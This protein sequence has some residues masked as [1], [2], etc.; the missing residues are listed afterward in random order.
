VTG[1]DNAFFGPGAGVGN[2]SGANNTFVGVSAGQSNTTESLNTF[3]GAH[4]LGAG[5]ITNATAIG[6]SA[7]VTRSN[8]LVLGSINNVNFAIADTKVGIG[9]TAPVDL[10]HV[11]GH[12]TAI[13]VTDGSIST[14]LF[15]ASS[16]GNGYVGTASASPFVLRTGDIDRVIIDASG[17]VGIGTGPDHTLSVNGN[18]DKPGGG[19]WDNLSDERLKTIRGRFT[20]GLKALRQ[21]QPLRYE[22]KR[23]NALGIKSDGEHIGFGAQS[24]Q[25]A[26]PEAVTRNDKGYLL[27][28]NDPIIWTMLNAIKEQ[29]K[30]I[31][32]LK[33][34]VGQLQ[35]AAHRQRVRRR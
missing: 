33:Q 12:G 32:Q 18:A 29:Q 19:S 4:A 20:P 3:I 10:L 23:D 30:E 22:Y 9:T 35:A 2:T 16:T 1:A 21:L 31:E 27:V 17:N 15:S 14:R 5:G 24:V 8:S 11:V 25:K 34:Q 6:A 13:R 26:I 7:Q 28:N